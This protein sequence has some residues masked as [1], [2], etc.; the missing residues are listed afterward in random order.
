MDEFY[1]V[2]EVAKLLKLNPQTVR[3]WIDRGDLPAVRVGARRVRIRASELD[4]FIEQ[5]RTAQ[6]PIGSADELLTQLEGL[7][8]CATSLGERLSDRADGPDD[9]RLRVE[10]LQRELEALIEKHRGE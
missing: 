7:S 8:T 9:E 1:T 4:R 10:Q 2:N 6:P 5:G 3:N